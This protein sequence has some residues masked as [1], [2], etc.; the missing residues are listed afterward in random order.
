[1]I[2]LRLNIEYLNTKFPSLLN[3]IC[4]HFRK[5]ALS[6]VLRK[7]SHCFAETCDRVCRKAWWEAAPIWADGRLAAVWSTTDEGL[8]LDG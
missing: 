5:L 6:A 3:S 4:E 2:Q 8:S 1:M 7:I